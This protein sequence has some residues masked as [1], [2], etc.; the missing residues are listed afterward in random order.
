MWQ[1]GPGRGCSKPTGDLAIGDLVL[2]NDRACGRQWPINSSHLDGKPAWMNDPTG[3]P[4]R[5]PTTDSTE[6]LP[7]SPSTPSKACLTRDPSPFHV[8][9]RQGSIAVRNPIRGRWSTATRHPGTQPVRQDED[10][11]PKEQWLSSLL[12]VQPPIGLN[13]FQFLVVGLHHKRNCSSFEPMA[14]LGQH[15]LH[16]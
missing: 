12:E 13:V 5:E 14:P 10:K 11:A 3:A 6:D 9:W 15:Q 8:A 1:D 4:W 16:C 2:S 7:D